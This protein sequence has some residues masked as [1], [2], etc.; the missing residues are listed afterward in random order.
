MGDEE[1]EV[2]VGPPQVL[3][4]GLDEELV[5]ERQSGVLRLERRSRRGA[6]ESCELP[7]PIARVFRLDLPRSGVAGP[8]VGVT[9]APA[10][11]GG[12]GVADRDAAARR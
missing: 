1:E 10:Y 9:L 4:Y 3:L 2:P 7:W 6:T 12:A 8:P 11:S 5:L